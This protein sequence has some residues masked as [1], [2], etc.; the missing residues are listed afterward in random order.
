MLIWQRVQMAKDDDVRVPILDG[1]TAAASLALR[2]LSP[3]DRAAVQALCAA[4]FPI[5]YP[6]CWFDEV[7]SGSLT[8]LG[9]FDDKQLVAMIVSETKN[10]SKCN[11]EDSD[12]ISNQSAL[13]V[14]ILSLAVSNDYRRMGLATRLLNCLFES[15]VNQPP[16]PR[17]VFLHVLS[18]NLP[19]INF[20]RS[21]GFRWHASLLNYYRIGSGFGDGC[22]YVKYTNGQRPPLS[23]SEVLRLVG[24]VV[25]F[26]LKT[27]CKLF[28]Y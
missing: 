11:L 19:A 1:S 14:Y 28:S 7:V 2:P 5:E 12:I 21:N 26:P 22:T 13:V 6:E 18:T 3:L 25:C 17:A 16:Y 23:I 24:V 8:S 15:V 10:I 9:L 4:S 27:L 20:Y